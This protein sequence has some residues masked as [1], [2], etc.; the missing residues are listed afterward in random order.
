M[1][2]PELPKEGYI[3][4]AE[5]TPVAQEIRQDVAER[6]AEQ[7]IQTQQVQMQPMPQNPA[8]VPTAVQ[9]PAPPPIVVPT[10]SVPVATQLQAEEMSHGSVESA[11]T[12]LG[13]Q[14]VF[15]LKKALHFG[16]KV[17]FNQA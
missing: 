3:P 15:K 9:M 11:Q 17:I 6:L 2:T 8:L 5:M 13:A 10:I 12:W 7:G 1:T 16:W 14:I 4:Q